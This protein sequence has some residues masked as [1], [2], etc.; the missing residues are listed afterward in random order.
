MLGDGPQLS[1]MFWPL[2][3][4]PNKLYYN[5]AHHR[6]PV[7]HVSHPSLFEVILNDPDVTVVQSLF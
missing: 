7:S 6:Y 4:Q 3:G 5:F 1:K 2:D